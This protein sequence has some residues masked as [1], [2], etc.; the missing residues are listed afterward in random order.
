[1]FDKHDHQPEREGRKPH[2]IGHVVKSPA[3]LGRGAKEDSSKG[4]ID[5]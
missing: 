1:M 3:W 4:V 2:I 5:S